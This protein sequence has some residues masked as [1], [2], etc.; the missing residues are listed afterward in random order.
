MGSDPLET[1]AHE[2]LGQLAPGQLA[3]VVHLLKVM[4]SDEEPVTAEDRL[5]FQGGQEWFER[6]GGKGIPMEDVLA[7]FGLKSDDFPLK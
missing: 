6:H 1:E 7:D 3:A 5:R 2:L 4:I